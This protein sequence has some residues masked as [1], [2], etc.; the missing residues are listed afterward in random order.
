MRDGSCV[1]CILV[2][3]LCVCMHV[4]IYIYDVSV[5]LHCARS[6]C[7]CGH[8]MHPTVYVEIGTRVCSAYA[9]AISMCGVYICMRDLLMCDVCVPACLCHL[10]AHM[11]VLVHN[12]VCARGMYVCAYACHGLPIIC[13]LGTRW[14]CVHRASSLGNVATY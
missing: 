7:N 12:P 2:S 9:S 10:A 1:G 13:A 4:Y 14:A 8:W 3:A 11:C 5:Y 6:V